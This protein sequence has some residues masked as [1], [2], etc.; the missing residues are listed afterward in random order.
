MNK[1]KKQG[2]FFPI[3]I[4][5]ILD[6]LKLDPYPALE[7][8]HPI[9]PM[10]AT[11]LKQRAAQEKLVETTKRLRVETTTKDV[12]IVLPTE[13]VPFDPTA[14]VPDVDD[15]DDADVDATGPSRSTTPL[16]LRAMMEMFMT[17][18]AAYGQLLGELIF[19][20]AALRADFSECRS[21]FPPPPPSNL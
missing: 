17:T 11:F 16:S 9:A 8:V 6:F 4:H 12:P 10:G 20:V 14:V 1:S 3:L 5:K 18:Q 21:F 7:S 2:L 13:E 19:E 15:E